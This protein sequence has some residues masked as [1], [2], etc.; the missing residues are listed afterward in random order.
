VRYPLDPSAL[1]LPESKAHELSDTMSFAVTS[2][3]LQSHEVQ[4]R[5][6]RH[7]R[8]RSGQ[9]TLIEQDHTFHSDGSRQAR[10][11]RDVRANELSGI[12]AAV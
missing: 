8:G 4:D 7:G 10:S 9:S 1:V 2:Q 6:A 12:L 11:Q 3:H 5:S